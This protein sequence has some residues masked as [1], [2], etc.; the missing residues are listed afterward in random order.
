MANHDAQP[1]TRITRLSR[2]LDT[3]RLPLGV[4]R[5]VVER[6]D[7]VFTDNMATLASRRATIALQESPLSFAA[8]HIPGLLD[9]K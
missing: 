9:S 2:G 8:L 7:A 5:S 6:R 3:G 1:R 4:G